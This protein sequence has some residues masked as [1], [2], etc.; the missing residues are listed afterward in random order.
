MPTDKPDHRDFAA[1]L[2]Q[3]VFT[4]AAETTP[5]LR[6]DM[7]RRAAGGPPIA[8]P[9]DDLAHQIGEAAYRVS[10][11]QMAAVRELAGTDRAAF[12]LV[13]AAA[14]GAA[15]KRWTAGLAAIDEASSA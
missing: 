13:A 10:D 1:R 8:P 12:E 4:E 2:E 15:L 7:G 11:A 9:Y 5:Q 6:Q 3:R 14:V